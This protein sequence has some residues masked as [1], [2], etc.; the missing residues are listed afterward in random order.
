[1]GRFV[2]VMAFLVCDVFRDD[3]VIFCCWCIVLVCPESVGHV[4]SVVHLVELFL[5][6]TT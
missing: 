6:Q 4:M 2:F 1:V 5:F 3:I